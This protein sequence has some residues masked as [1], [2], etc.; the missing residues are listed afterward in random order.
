MKR[1]E[2]DD[3]LYQKLQEFAIPFEETTPNMVLRRIIDHYLIC[4]KKVDPINLISP[5]RFCIREYG[6][7]HHKHFRI[8][9][10]ETLQELGGKGK[11]REVIEI[12]FSKV[13]D[14]LTEIDYSRTATG[15]I[16]WRDTVHSKH[17]QMVKEGILKSDSPRGI[18]ELNPDFN[19]RS[20]GNKTETSGEANDE[21]V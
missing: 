13:R 21:S 3:N 16:R 15:I 7:L 6:K 19:H 12:V 9:I 14:K 17:S 20:D 5:S 4:E 10:I 1:I 2:L 11:S 8:P 18:W